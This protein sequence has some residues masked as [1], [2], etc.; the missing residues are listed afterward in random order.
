M[1]VES[2]AGLCYVSLKAASDLT[3]RPCGCERAIDGEHC[4]RIQTSD[5]S[6]SELCNCAEAADKGLVCA[7]A[8]P[9]GVKLYP[10]LSAQAYEYRD[11]GSS[12][13]QFGYLKFKV[14]TGSAAAEVDQTGGGLSG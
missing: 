6:D 4:L 3:S 12:F 8:G 13:V 10:T 5:V 9:A 11:S 14:S 7:L 2:T 1:F